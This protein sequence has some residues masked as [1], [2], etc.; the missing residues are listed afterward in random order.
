MIRLDERAYGRAILNEV[1]A[2]LDV[3][4]PRALFR[5][6]WNGSNARLSSARHLGRTPIR[7]GRARR[8]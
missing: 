3:T 7:D 6:P 2:R 5:R 1:A 8:F 4:S